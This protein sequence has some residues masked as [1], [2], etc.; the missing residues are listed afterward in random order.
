MRGPQRGAAARAAPVVRGEVEGLQAALVVL[1]VGELVQVTVGPARGEA[2]GLRAALVV[3]V[4]RAAGELVRRTVGWA[5]GSE[6]SPCRGCDRSTACRPTSAASV[7]RRDRGTSRPQD[8]SSQAPYTAAERWLRV[9]I[10]RDSHD[11]HATGR[12]LV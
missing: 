2:E 1:A 12:S 5:V 3:L 4:A 7:L 9:P 10:H 8:S 11:R 6:V